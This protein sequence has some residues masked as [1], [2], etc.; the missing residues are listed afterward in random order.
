MRRPCELDRIDQL[1]DTRRLWVRRI[2]I[3]HGQSIHVAS[4]LAIIEHSIIADN[5][6]RSG[7]SP[8]VAG[9]LTVYPLIGPATGWLATAAASAVVGLVVGGVIVAVMHFIPRGKRAAH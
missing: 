9:P 5:S 8:D 3:N 4:G 2:S 1:F 6:D 7:A